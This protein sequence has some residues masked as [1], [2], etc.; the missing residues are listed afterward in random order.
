MAFTPLTYY[1]LLQAM[2]QYMSATSSVNEG[3][4][5]AVVRTMFESIAYTIDESYFQLVNVIESYYINSASGTDLDRRGTDYNQPRFLAQQSTVNLTFSGVNGTT[6]SPGLICSVLATATTAQIDFLTTA[7]GV[8]TGGIVVIEAICLTAGSVGN[9]A[10]GSI[11][12]I[13]N[14]PNSALITGVTN[15]SQAEGGFDQE[16]DPVYRARLIAYLQSLSQGTAQA[17]ISA[18]LNIAGAGITQCKVLEFNYTDLSLGYSLSFI[19]GGN[20]TNQDLATTPTA[21]LVQPS[22][23]SIL[24]VIDNGTGSLPLTSVGAGLPVLNG[25]PSNPTTYPGTRAAGIQGFIT[26]P[27]NSKVEISMTVN[28]APNII[29]TSATI[30]AIQTALSNYVIS[31]PIGGTFYISELVDAALNVSGVINV[32]LSSLNPTSDQSPPTPTSKFV[33]AATPTITIGT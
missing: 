31:I 10:P 13:Q 16:S 27:A 6:V 22:P 14:N 4:I 9:V 17:I 11:N 1:Q 30:I 26:R 19:S 12:T 33:L 7:S 29:D 21:T 3:N 8:I 18:M 25:V 2:L 15:P 23:G 32:V 28:L 5:G 20:N 24:V